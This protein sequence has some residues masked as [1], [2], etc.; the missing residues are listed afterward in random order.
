[1]FN[2]FI[3]KNLIIV[4]FT[5][6]LFVLFLASVFLLYDYKKTEINRT[7]KLQSEKLERLERFITSYNTINLN[8]LKTAERIFLNIIQ[9]YEPISKVENDSVYIDL[10]DKGISHKT[11]I[12]RLLINGQSLY[13]NNKIPE[14]K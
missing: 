14:R 10:I 4:F 13:L 2:K 7:N 3:Q 8:K 6:L 1:M 5:A 9:K 12:N 11:K